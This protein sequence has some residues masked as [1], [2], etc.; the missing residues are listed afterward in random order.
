MHI[1]PQSPGMKVLHT[2]CIFS[3]FVPFPFTFQPSSRLPSKTTTNLV[4]TSA[5][6]PYFTY[7]SRD[8]LLPQFPA[9]AP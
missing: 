9:A 3:L 8:S 7:L 4:M 6:I 1:M 5:S 2:C